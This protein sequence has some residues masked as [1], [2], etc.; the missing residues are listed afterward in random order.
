MAVQ[1][2]SGQPVQAGKKPQAVASGAQKKKPSPK[3]SSQQ[4]QGDKK[5]Q[6]TSP[7]EQKKEASPKDA[8]PQGQGDKK[9]QAMSSEQQR[10]EAAETAA[11]AMEYKKKPSII[12]TQRTAALTQTSA[13]TFGKTAKYLQTGRWQGFV[14]GSGLGVGI[15]AAV[16]TLTGT[17]VGGPTS[18]ITGGIGA[19]AGAIHGPF[20]NIAE[21][22]GSA[23]RKITGDL[24]GWKATPEQKRAL[25]K[26]CGQVSEMEEPTAEELQELAGKDMGD[27]DAIV[28]S[29]KESGSSWAQSASSMLPSWGSGQENTEKQQ[30]IDAAI[31][32]QDAKSKLQGASDEKAKTQSQPKQNESK[33]T[34]TK[35][36]PSAGENGAPNARPKPRKLGKPSATSEK[37]PAT[38][39]PSTDASKANGTGAGAT[40]QKNKPLTSTNCDS[41]R[42]DMPSSASGTGKKPPKL[43][44]GSTGTS[45]TN[46]T[47]PGAQSQTPSIPARRAP[48]KLESR[49]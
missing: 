9:P 38:S 26:M 22:G 11:K 24:P 42:R 20:V 5:A 23:I 12:G 28:A 33:Q 29:G 36:S 8:S 37:Q 7:T 16:G 44:S 2:S 46:G 32:Q 47:K 18:L 17:L 15:G 10:R 49:A 14:A 6:A 34:P 19:I 30:Q 25:E 4:G 48:R 35:Q 39:A 3:G 31:K 43:Q 27:L 41:K 21:W 1:Q 40:P 45:K 13:E